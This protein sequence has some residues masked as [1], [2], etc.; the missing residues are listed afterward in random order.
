MEASGKGAEAIGWEPRKTRNT[1][2]GCWLLVVRDWAGR[3][4][5][6]SFPRL[7]E[8]AN[9]GVPVNYRNPLE[10]ALICMALRQKV[11][12][13]YRRRGFRR[14]LPRRS[15][16]DLCGSQFRSHGSTV[17]ARKLHPTFC[18]RAIF[19]F[20]GISGGSGRFKSPNHGNVAGRWAS[21]FSSHPGGIEP[22]ANPPLSRVR[23]TASSIF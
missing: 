19:I 4:P 9:E 6:K 10:L 5:R 2:T 17:L 15:S 12:S 16:T 7:L 18:R 8:W 20:G 14:W 21:R 11:E 1:G 3:G 22:R 23:C 13:A